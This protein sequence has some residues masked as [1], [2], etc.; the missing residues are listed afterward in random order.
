MTPAQILN[1]IHFLSPTAWDGFR[2]R[3]AKGRKLLLQGTH[4]LVYDRAHLFV[5]FTKIVGPSPFDGFD[6]D[7][8]THYTREDLRLEL[9]ETA[10]NLKL[11]LRYTQDRTIALTC[12]RIYF[13]SAV[14][15]PPTLQEIVDRCYAL[16]DEYDYAAYFGVEGP[17][18]AEE[19]DR[20]IRAEV[21]PRDG[22]A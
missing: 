20:R 17:L 10:P 18:D 4:D 3:M 1:R 13:A 15:E 9:L 11:L 6:E 22:R 12:G 21:R 5:L 2:V 16:R 14:R 19:I 7:D 8:R